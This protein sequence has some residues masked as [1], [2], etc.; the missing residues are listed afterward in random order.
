MPTLI[1]GVL[2]KLIS[3]PNFNQ[4]TGERMPD[5]YN[6]I[7]VTFVRQEGPDYIWIMRQATIGDIKIDYDVNNAVEIPLSKEHISKYF[8][9]FE[10]DRT[11]GKKK[12]TT[13]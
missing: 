12:I 4:E 7:L 13:K 6:T 5:G 2:Y 8:Y 9:V 1:P 11:G 10:A 3:K